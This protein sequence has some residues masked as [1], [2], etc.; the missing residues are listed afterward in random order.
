MHCHNCHQTIPDDSPFCIHCG[1]LQK[2]NRIKPII[3]TIAGA[4][5]SFT[6]SCAHLFTGLY[7]I[8]SGIS[9]RSG[10]NNFDNVVMTG[11]AIMIFYV[12]FLLIVPMIMRSYEIKY[13]RRGYNIGNI[14]FIVLMISTLLIIYERYF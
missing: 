5:V 6:I 8:F 3:N 1:V 11:V 14:L 13:F 12:F 4:I 7:L 9:F 2:Q 10:S